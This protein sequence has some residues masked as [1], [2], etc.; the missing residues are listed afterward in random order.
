M[1]WGMLLVLLG[2]A[3][4]GSVPTPTD[5]FETGDGDAGI[6]HP[7]AQGMSCG[8]CHNIP[9]GVRNGP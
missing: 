3:A 6:V 7:E 4:C 9:E 2:F 1:R 5:P 8:Q